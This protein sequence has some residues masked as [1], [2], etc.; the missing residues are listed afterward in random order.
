VYVLT[1]F[2]IASPEPSNPFLRRS[3]RH[4]PPHPIPFSVAGR[5]IASAG[6]AL[7]ALFISYIFVRQSE[8][9]DLLSMISELLGRDKNSST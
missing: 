2:R 4:D 5:R 6:R 9:E 3:F 7:R 8:P 1:G